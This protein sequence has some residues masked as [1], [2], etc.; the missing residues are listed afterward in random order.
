MSPKER[1]K[2]KVI[3]QLLLEN[4]VVSDSLIS[5]LDE[6]LEKALDNRKSMIEEGYTKR[7]L[8]FTPTHVIDYL[9]KEGKICQSK[10]TP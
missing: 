2:Q 3:T 7:T 4:Y 9:I 8:K 6:L 1:M 10:S 5:Y